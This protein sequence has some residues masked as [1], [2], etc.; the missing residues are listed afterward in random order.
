MT[1]QANPGPAALSGATARAVWAIALG[2]MLAYGCYYYVF[3]A[4]IFYWRRDMPLGDGTLA[5]G[6][7][8]AVMVAAGLAPLS[9]R[10]VDRG[11][12][13]HLM[14]VGAGAGALSLALLACADGPGVYLLA[15]AGLGVAQGTCLY[16][17]CFA[18]MIRRFGPDARAA[19]T[20]ITLVAG[21]ASTLMFPAA[22]ALA[23][24]QG[25]RA[26][27]WA[28]AAVGVGV[29]LPV[30]L[31]GARQLDR[32]AP[33]TGPSDPPATLPPAIT[34]STP[35]DWRATLRHPLFWRLGVM[36]AA[37][38]MAHWM[39]LAFVRPALAAI[40]LGDGMAVLAAAL[41]GPAQV[42]GRLILLMLGAR[43][44]GRAALRL[45]LGGF[46]LGPA[47]LI[48]AGVAAKLH[49][50]AA[51]AGAVLGFALMQGA[52]N[53]VM[54]IL[55]PMLV[56]GSLGA[57]GYGATAG[58]LSVPTLLASAAAPVAGAA[59][60]GMGGWLGLAGLALAL[61]CVGLVLAGPLA[62]TPMVGETP[63]RAA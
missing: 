43:L 46:V 28:A 35:Q 53:G 9:G 29:I 24:A 8:L 15:W 49:F 21:F 42:L 50:G 26:A 25:W 52:A 62:A 48:A 34:A 38:A 40:G 58:M 61:A 6:M 17:V 57:A 27:V 37:V 10:A 23:T 47:L 55:R 5:T 11:Y 16:E 45:T 19:I 2:Q 54:T 44:S 39:L 20:R 4:L 18:L 59:A 7:T 63:R 60:M 1:G 31:W 12:G 41:I 36:F 32:P 22:A 30:N 56:A 13:P 14:S 51:L 33:P 3:A